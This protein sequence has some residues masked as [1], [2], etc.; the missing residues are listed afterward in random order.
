MGKMMTITTTTMTMTITT[1]MMVRGEGLNMDGKSGVLFW[2]FC[3]CQ[4]KMFV[5]FLFFFA[6]VLP[7]RVGPSGIEAVL[8]VE[9]VSIPSDFFLSD[10]FFYHSLISMTA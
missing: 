5:F 6:D 10:C 7:R 2:I 1:M 3:F 9:D 8:V 4:A